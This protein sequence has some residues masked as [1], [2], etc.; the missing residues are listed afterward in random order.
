[1]TATDSLCDSLARMALMSSQEV[2]R[3]RNYMAETR[4]LRC[5]RYA[6]KNRT[7]AKGPAR[8]QIDIIPWVPV[9]PYE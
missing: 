4:R 2:T 7:E 3:L 9:R 6:R 8:F 1:M 5:E